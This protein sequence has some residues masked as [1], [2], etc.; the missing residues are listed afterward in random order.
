MRLLQIEKHVLP[1]GVRGTSRQFNG[2][3]YIARKEQWPN[4]REQVLKD[5][6]QQIVTREFRSRTI[7]YQQMKCVQT[8]GR[9]NSNIKEVYLSV[10][11]KTVRRALM[12]PKVSL[13]PMVSIVIR[14]F[15]NRRVQDFSVDYLLPIKI[16]DVHLG[17][18][19]RDCVP[20][21]ALMDSYDITNKAKLFDP[22]FDLK[23]LSGFTNPHYN[24]LRVIADRDVVEKRVPFT[25]ASGL[26]HLAGSESK[27][28]SESKSNRIRPLL[29]YRLC[30]KYK[31]RM[32]HQD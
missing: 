8:T 12:N 9:G 6:K 16:S 29:R 24:R 28:S 7:R 19:Y 23:I 27:S 4:Q 26:V 11:H 17:I 22:H 15:R 1:L 10:L 25:K 20:V 2:H 14:K 3:R 21:Q 13:I 18:V 30:V 31:E 5:K 32:D